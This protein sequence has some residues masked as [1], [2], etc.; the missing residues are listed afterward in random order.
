[1]TLEK[2]ISTNFVS[3]L[4]T[5]YQLVANSTLLQE[6]IEFYSEI[7][8]GINIHL[9]NG[10]IVTILFSIFNTTAIIV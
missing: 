10:T 5:N 1:M 7:E 9:E 3:S 2:F 8:G 4:I 6:E